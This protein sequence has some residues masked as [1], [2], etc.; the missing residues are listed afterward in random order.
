MSRLPDGTSSSVLL[1][2]EAVIAAVLLD[3]EAYALVADLEPGDFWNEQHQKIWGAC[4]WLADREQLVTVI[5]VAHELASRN[6]LKEGL[7][8][9]LLQTIVGRWFTSVGIEANARIVTADA[10]RRRLTRLG[11]EIVREANRGNLDRAR[12]LTDGGGVSLD[13][14]E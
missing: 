8:E 12:D 7:D 9:V 1:A 14:G 5:T 13:Y 6:E 11:A 4:Q 10:E 3:A 2:E